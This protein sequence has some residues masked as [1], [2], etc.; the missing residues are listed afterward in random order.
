MKAVASRA[1]KYMQEYN[2]FEQ[3]ERDAAAAEDLKP[4]SAD[5]RI[6]STEG[7]P[8]LL[9]NTTC[10]L[11]CS[12]GA[13]RMTRRTREPLNPSLKLGQRLNRNGQKR[14]TKL[15][16]E[17]LRAAEREGGS[18]SSRLQGGEATLGDMLGM[19]F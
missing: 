2:P 5:L 12:S 17:M 14:T 4:S 1:A 15:P 8:Q 11:S 13:T 7:R 16:K 3:A 9:M 6:R 18:A 19:G 10:D